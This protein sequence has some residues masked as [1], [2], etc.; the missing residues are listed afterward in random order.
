MEVNRNNDTQPNKCTFLQ[1]VIVVENKGL[2]FS[3]VTLE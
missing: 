3:V 2:Y 1:D